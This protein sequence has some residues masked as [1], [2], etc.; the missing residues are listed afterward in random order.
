MVSGGTAPRILNVGTTYL[1]EVNCQIHATAA[2][3]MGNDP[4]PSGSHWV[5]S[6]VGPRTCL[7]PEA[8]RKNSLSI[9]K[10]KTI[11]PAR[12]LVTMLIGS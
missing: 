10:S 6:W 12:S 2:L 5:G 11:R 4:S 1:A 3:L 7:N 9:W 8:K